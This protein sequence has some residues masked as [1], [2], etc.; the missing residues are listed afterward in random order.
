MQK[1][2]VNL[3]GKVLGKFK[4]SVGKAQSKFHTLPNFPINSIQFQTFGV[5]QCM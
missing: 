1:L 4:Y 2:C 5:C 3:S